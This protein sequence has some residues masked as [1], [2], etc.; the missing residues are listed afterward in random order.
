MEGEA[1]ISFPNGRLRMEN[2][3]DPAL[4]QKSNFVYWCPQNLP[5]NIALT[6]E[7]YPIQEP[8]LAI[9]FFAA[10]GINGEDIFDAKLDKR[11]GE[12]Q[13]YHHGDINAFH[14]S[15]F[16]R[17]YPSE[18]A[19]NLCNLRKSYGFHMVMQGAD[20]IPAVADAKP[21]YFI[22]LIKKTN[23]VAF[24]INGLPIFRYVDDGKTYGK[25]IRNGK[26]GFRQMAPLIAEY[27]NLKVYKLK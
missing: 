2:A 20:P 19:F 27:S 14:V 4:G 11:S 15:Y 13:Q 17:K 12:Y 1:K 8:G 18:R 10:T 26:I 22:K 7:F 9:L 16:R 5:D 3:L 25:F 6:W 21:P 23:E 24:F